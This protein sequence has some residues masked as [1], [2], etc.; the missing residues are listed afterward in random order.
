VGRKHAGA[1][2]C[3]LGE[4]V[5]G[6]DCRSAGSAVKKFRNRLRHDKFLARQVTKIEGHLQKEEM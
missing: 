4:A 5:S 1:K 6:I 2:L 3:E